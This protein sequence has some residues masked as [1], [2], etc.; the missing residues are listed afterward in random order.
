MAS[1]HHRKSPIV[2]S[3][4]QQAGSDAAPKCFHL[5]ARHFTAHPL[6][7]APTES[8]LLRELV[9]RQG[10]FRASQPAIAAW[11]S[12]RFLEVPGQPPASALL[13]PPPSRITAHPSSLAGH[14]IPRAAESVP[15][16]RGTG[17]DGPSGTDPHQGGHHHRHSVVPEHTRRLQTCNSYNFPLD[18]PHTKD[19]SFSFPCQA[20]HLKITGRMATIIMSDFRLVGGLRSEDAAHRSS[21]DL[22][23]RRDGVGRGLHPGRTPQA[24]AILP[25]PRAPRTFRNR[26]L[27]LSL[28][29]HRLPSR[30][31]NIHRDR[32]PIRV[33]KSASAAGPSPRS[34]RPRLGSGRTPR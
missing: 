12:I 16:V 34:G 32:R 22:G 5:F 23:E 6:A 14:L 17:S 21:R 7:I 25:A 18:P 20:P 2:P 19:I 29:I 28:S 30:R 13:R 33:S 15:K 1:C 10:R 11:M 9:T 3:R 31:I 26:L 8:V 24:T 4:G 27:A